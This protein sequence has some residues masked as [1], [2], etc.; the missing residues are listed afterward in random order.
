[1]DD[2]ERT[3]CINS[4]SRAKKAE[5]CLRYLDEIID[6][7]KK[8]LLDTFVEANI[9]TEEHLKELVI[10]KH[11]FDGIIGLRDIIESH[12]NSGKIAEAKLN[13]G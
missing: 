13:G 6:D 8:T 4:I 12:I 11:R 10:L 2:A 5:G 7:Y 3:Y 1:M 9:E